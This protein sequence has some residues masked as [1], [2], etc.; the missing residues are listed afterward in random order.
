L[1]K[2]PFTKLAATPEQLLQKLEAR[3]LV[4]SAATQQQA[5]A[6][7]RFVGGYRLKGYWFHVVDPATKQF[8]TGYTFELIAARCELD[9]EL[10]AATITA[11]DRLE[12]AIRSVMANF[13][14][15]KHSPH[16]FLSSGIFKPSREWGIGQLIRKIEDEVKRSEGKRFVG[17]YYDRHDDPYLP[18]SWAISE[19]VTFGLWS[20]TFAILRDANDK[21]AISKKFGIDQAEV[22][23]S[24]I[25]TLTVVRNIAAHHGQLLKV[26]LGV[27]P[28]NYK[29]GGIKFN[30]QKSFFAAATVIHYLL[31]QTG[32]P[33]RWK[34]DLDEIFNKYPSVDIAD[35]GFPKNWK[36]SAGW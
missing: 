6:Y 12:V 27:S 26:K 29:T 10:R 14:S 4:V 3:G 21:K 15:L 11:I 24:W 17:H 19:C 35:L 28:S 16:W 31:N 34:S 33:H 30:D 32:L 8:P 7:L 9:R 5:L 36:T 13:L 25:H 18:P 2:V 22:F 1:A 20:R 23:Q